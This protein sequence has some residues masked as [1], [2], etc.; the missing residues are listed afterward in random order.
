VSELT[1]YQQPAPIAD[2]QSRAI[3]R[4]GAWAQSA[5]AAYAVAQR[6]VQSSF[7]PQAFRGK[8][9]EATAAILAGAEVG[10]NPMASLRAFD[11]IQGQAAPR[12]LTLRAVAQSHGH[13]IEIVES[14]ATR[15][16]VRARRRGADWQPVTWT[17]DRAKELGLTGKDNWRKQPQAMLVAR[18]T[19]E[20]A[21][22][23]AADAILGIGY[24]AEE[25]ADGASGDTPT[26]DAGPSEAAPAGTRR[27]SRRKPAEE[28]PAA[29]HEPVE[30]DKWEP[31]TEP[32]AP[33]GPP[34]TPTPAPADAEPE[35][36]SDKQLTA[37]A[38]LAGKLGL[39]REQKLA[40]LSHYA[41]RP[42]DTSKALTKIEATWCI[43]A[44][45]AKVDELPVEEPPVA[46]NGAWEQD[47]PDLLDAADEGDGQ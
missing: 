1:H 7:V 28:T 13:D 14:T 42:I 22:L 31:V 29:N 45:K 17:I 32:P 30:P 34:P 18:A 12:A 2:Y 43:D 19:S 41:G 39:T 36:I 27:M 15:C 16:R 4:L 11:V 46:E 6:L 8:P 38:T 35:P 26:F 44:M 21:R 37:I 20:A 3:D 10:L 24:S 25:V 40:G 5:D 33:T 9:V 47:G 23:V